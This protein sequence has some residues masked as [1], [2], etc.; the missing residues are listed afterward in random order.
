MGHEVTRVALPVTQLLM[1]WASTIP[2]GHAQ[3]NLGEWG[4]ICGAG[5][6]RYWQPPLGRAVLSHQFTPGVGEETSQGDTETPSARLEDSR[7]FQEKFRT[8]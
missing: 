2:S 8:F 7:T 6:H 4:L 5:R 3:V 1:S